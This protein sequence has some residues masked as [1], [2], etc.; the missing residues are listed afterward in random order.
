LPVAEF[1]SQ[2]VL[3]PLVRVFAYLMLQEGLLSEPHTQ[4]VVYKK[5]ADGNLTGEIRFRD[6]DSVKPDFQLR[7]IL[8]RTLQAYREAARDFKL[9][10]PEATFQHQKMTTNYDDAYLFYVRGEW[11]ERIARALKNTRY[12]LTTSQIEEIIDI[13]MLRE[14]VE[15]LGAKAV[16]GARIEEV[17]R[18]NPTLA[19]EALQ[20]RP[21]EGS[22][23]QV[24]A[25]LRVFKPAS[26]FRKYSAARSVPF[27]IQRIV[28]NFK[29]AELTQ[30]PKLTYVRERDLQVNFACRSLFH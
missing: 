4:N 21:Y 2:K 14:T 30:N 13:L 11:A 6:L 26:I 19:E 17:L 20:G 29:Q 8:G 16:F 25:V 18:D 3:G 1:L 12:E 24:E 7:K 9:S 10:D 22:P 23:E 28:D 27:S 15:H 5:D